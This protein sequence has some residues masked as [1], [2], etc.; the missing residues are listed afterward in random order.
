MKTQLSRN[1]GSEAAMGRGAMK[2]NKNKNKLTRVMEL[3]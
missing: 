1:F 3:F 2:E